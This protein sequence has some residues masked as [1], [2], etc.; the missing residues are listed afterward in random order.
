MARSDFG[1]ARTGA[2]GAAGSA[3]G[4]VVGIGARTIDARNA[5]SSERRQP[6]RRSGRGSGTGTRNLVG[7]AAAMDF[8]DSGH[9]GNPAQRLS[10]GCREPELRRSFL[11]GE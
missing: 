1:K 5:I 8:E 9:D 10:L 7:P 11:S 6:I 4:S 3:R 2:G